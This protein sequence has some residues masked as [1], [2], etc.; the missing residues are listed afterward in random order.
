MIHLAVELGKA[1]VSASDWDLLIMSNYLP[2]TW[3]FDAFYL[4]QLLTIWDYCNNQQQ[5]AFCDYWK[6]KDQILISL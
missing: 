5:T 3:L 2:I 1:K 6:I 4:L